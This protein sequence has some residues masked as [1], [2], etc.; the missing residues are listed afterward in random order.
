MRKGTLLL[1]RGVTKFSFPPFNIEEST[2]LTV[3]RM[4]KKMVVRPVTSL[5][6]QLVT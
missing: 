5:P 2:V 4:E 3:N 1:P 6:L